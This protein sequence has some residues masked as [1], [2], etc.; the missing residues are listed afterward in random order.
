MCLAVREWE[1]E[2]KRIGEN[3]KMIKLVQRK[4]QKEKTAE[5][6]AEELEEP[7]ENVERVCE[8]VEECGREADAMM[9]YEWMQDNIRV[10]KW[11]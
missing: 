11:L 5:T 9:I 10:R 3:L 7:L 2:A 8:A 4:L 6:I 1:A